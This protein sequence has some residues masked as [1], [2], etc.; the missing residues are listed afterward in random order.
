M[1]FMK[2]SR[3]KSTNPM[4]LVNNDKY[5][6]TMDIC[7]DG[8]IIYHSDLVNTDPTLLDQAKGGLLAP[9]QYYGIVGTKQ[10][11]QKAI[12][13]FDKSTD[14]DKINTRNDLTDDMVTL[15]SLKPN[16]SAG[17]AM[18]M[19]YILI[20]MGGYRQDYSEGCMTVHPDDW[21]RLLPL[22][23]INEK[24]LVQLV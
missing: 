14:L 17:G 20:H 19:Q 5:D 9:G 22:L 12:W 4:T 18:T 15:P 2:I 6:S 8:K 16:Q 23:A 7:Q 24:V 11:G 13:L 1:K 21:A 10:Y 3:G